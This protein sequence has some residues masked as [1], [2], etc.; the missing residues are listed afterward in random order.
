[1]NVRRRIQGRVPRRAYTML[2]MVIA[3]PLMALLLVGTTAALGI[4]A[5]VADNGA[6]VGKAV[7][8]TPAAWEQ[9]ASELECATSI[10][11][12]SATEISV[13]IPDRTGD[14]AADT[15]AYSWSGMDGEPLTRRINGG[16]AETLLETV[17]AFGMTYNTIT[18]GTTQSA[19]SIDLRLV[20][21][22]AAAPEI[23]VRVRLLNEPVAP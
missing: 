5:Q 1:M 10:V 4:V 7:M 12:R 11:S 18:V 23:V 2:E 16:T 20:T 6:S 9:L 13:V 15:V 14:A 8:R 3:L 19:Q 22:T 21:P 17:H